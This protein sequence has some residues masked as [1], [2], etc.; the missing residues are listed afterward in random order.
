VRSRSLLNNKEN[1]TTMKHS[2]LI[3]ST[4]LVETAGA[5]AVVDALTVARELGHVLGMSARIGKG[6]TEDSMAVRARLRQMIAATPETARFEL[7]DL[8]ESVTQ[9]V[10]SDHDPEFNLSAKGCSHCS[11]N[12]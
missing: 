1:T 7:E 3:P 9:H 10:I 6:D 5:P 2:T 11:R 8:T 12:G 4:E